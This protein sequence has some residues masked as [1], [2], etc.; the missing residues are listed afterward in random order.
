M[1]WFFVWTALALGTLLGAF[2]LGR[3]LWRKGIALLEELGRAAEVLGVLAERTAELADAAAAAAPAR[4][5]LL[6][7]PA[8][9]R[10]TVD[11][12]REERAERAALRAERHRQTFA[13]W[14][15]YSR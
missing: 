12:L 2:W 8:T 4:P 9:H 10:V 15:A 7:D 6:D 1:L 13:R 11:R 14:R 5:Q 3:D